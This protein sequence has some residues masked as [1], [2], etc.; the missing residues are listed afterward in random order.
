MPA[1]MAYSSSYPQELKDI[2]H[3]CGRPPGLEVFILSAKYG[4]IHE[5]FPIRNYDQIMSLYRIQKLKDQVTCSFI[6]ILRNNPQIDEIFLLMSEKYYHIIDCQRLSRY[7]KVT[8]INANY[9]GLTE[10]IVSLFRGKF[11]HWSV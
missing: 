9:T 10:R 6:S 11:P 4:L 2:F 5:N 3:T 1:L 7:A 8:R